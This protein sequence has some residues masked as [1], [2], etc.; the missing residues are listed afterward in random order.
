MLRRLFQ[1]A[2]ITFLLNLLAHV[3]SPN[4]PQPTGILP[5][6]VTPQIVMDLL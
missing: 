1:A 4:T 5:A 3:N 2:T 6:R